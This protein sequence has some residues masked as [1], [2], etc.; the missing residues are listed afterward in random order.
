M[1]VLKILL[2]NHPENAANYEH[3]TNAFKQPSVSSEQG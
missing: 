1:N 3:N 2:E